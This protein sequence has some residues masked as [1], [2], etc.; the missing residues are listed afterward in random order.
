VVIVVKR[1]GI[2]V[3]FF[4]R[5]ALSTEI[6]A[7]NPAVGGI[8]AI[9]AV[10]MKFSHLL[11]SSIFVLLLLIS[12]IINTTVDQYVIRKNITT[13]VFVMAAMIAQL[14]LNTE[15]KAIIFMVCF[16]FI[17]E[18]TP[19]APVVRQNAMEIL[20][21]RLWISMI[22]IVFCQVIRIVEVIFSIFL[23]ISTIH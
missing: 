1:I 21:F 2:R 16:V 7:E 13:M 4:F 8:P 5:V 9:F 15:E 19:M 11:V 3:V 18:I 20:L 23:M 10:D 6:F 22:G 12:F 14:L 17:W